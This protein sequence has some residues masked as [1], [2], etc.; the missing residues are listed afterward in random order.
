MAVRLAS[1]PLIYLAAEKDFEYTRLL[2]SAILDIV[3]QPPP[4]G[5]GGRTALNHQREIE[6]G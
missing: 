4:L 2:S 1:A 3:Q 6:L 5:L